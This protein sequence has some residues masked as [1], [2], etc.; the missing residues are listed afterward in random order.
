MNIFRF[1][2]CVAIEK[3]WSND[4]KYC[5]TDENGVKILLRISSAEQYGAKKFEFAMMEKLVQLNIPMCIPLEFGACDEGV[6][7]LQSWIEGT[8]LEEIIH[9]F[10]SEKQ[11]DLGLE[12]GRVLKQI[13]SIP[14]PKTQEPW[15]LHFNRKIDRNIKNYV[16][17]P[18][19]FDGSNVI[20]D[21][22]NDNRHLLKD[23]PQVFQHGDY[24]VG[25]MMFENGKVVIIDFNRHDFGDPWEEFNRI[26]WCAQKSPLFASGMLN[27]YFNGN[28]PENFWRLLALYIGSNTLSSIPWAISFGQ[29]EVDTMLNQAKEVLSWYD[30]MRKIVPTW[31]N[32][33]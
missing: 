2:T 10:S 24:H 21:Y 12:A 33:V 32:R 11:Y 19:K 3:G 6:Y 14:A 5:V 23:R 29:S 15:D 9:T 18:I 31:Y 16:D 17:C 8:D 1:K 25:N 20:I 26:V 13:H 28:P 30:D 27:G 22:I 7:S 4:K